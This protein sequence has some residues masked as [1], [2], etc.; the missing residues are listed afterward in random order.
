MAQIKDRVS[1]GQGEFQ[2]GRNEK[3]TTGLYL[4]TSRYR[5][6][7]DLKK[8]ATRCKDEWEMQCASI[9]KESS[10]ETWV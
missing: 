10:R 8:V 3:M 6:H 7:L 9:G 1:T 5:I 2:V 4:M